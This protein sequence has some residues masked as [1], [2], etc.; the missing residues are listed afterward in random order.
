MIIIEP[1]VEKEMETLDLGDK[2]L[3]ERAMKIVSEM[4]QQPTGSI[5]EF[6]SD[7]AAARGVYNFC[8]NKRAEGEQVLQSHKEATLERIKEGGYQRDPGLVRHHGIQLPKP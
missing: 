6:S 1:W 5:P 7:W 8:D 3:K 4:S 2:R